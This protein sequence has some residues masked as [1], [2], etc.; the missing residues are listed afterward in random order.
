M[1]TPRKSAVLII[2][3]VIILPLFIIPVRAEIVPVEWGSRINDYALQVDRNTTAEIVVYVVQSLK[4]HGIKD[5]AGSEIT[6]I[7]KLGVYIFNDMPLGTRDGTVVGIGKKGKDNGV[8]VL[9]AIDERE[10]RIE[11]G[12]GLEGDITDIESNRI[13]QEYMVPK[14]K[15]GNYGEGLYDAVVALGGKISVLNQ[16]S[17]SEVRGTYFY[18]NGSYIDSYGEEPDS[19]FWVIIIFVVF[20]V[21]APLVLRGGRG[22]GGRGG[23]Y[24]GGGGRSGG[25]GSGGKW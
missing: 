2:L 12:Y 17:S 7:V 16:T 1:T 19:L 3:A 11:V 25:G 4:G 14:F 9:V 6:E 24:G 20:G 5:K 23:G 8:L 18:E 15:E 21:F 22:R 13:A 10:W